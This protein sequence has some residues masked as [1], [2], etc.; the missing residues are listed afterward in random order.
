MLTVISASALNELVE[1]M[2]VNFP[3]GDF[4]TVRETLPFVR[5]SV[6]QDGYTVFSEMD[7]A[8]CNYYEALTAQ[9]LMENVDDKEQKLAF[10]SRVL[11]DDHY[12]T[13]TI[14]TIYEK[15]DQ[16]AWSTS[17]AALQAIE[18]ELGQK[19]WQYAAMVYR[20]AEILAEHGKIN[21]SL[22][23]VKKCQKS[24]TSTSMK[25]HWLNGC[26][27]II[28][29]V[30]YSNLQKWDDMLPG[31]QAASDIFVKINK[32]IME[33]K[34]NPLAIG[35]NAH[36]GYYIT[37]TSRV[38]GL[39]KES[40]KSSESMMKHLES[41]EMDNTGLANAYRSNMAISYYKEK[42]Y[43]KS[44]KMM[45]QYLDYLEKKGEKGSQMYNYIDN[46]LKQTPR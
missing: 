27:H 39:N 37:T 6:V 26:L 9:F 21:E 12:M 24:Y 18:D 16:S 15:F 33:N 4:Y 2:S 3:D 8:F 41:M 31:Y 40:I 11:G 19:S 32:D 29:S 5:N 45:T 44:R 46:L 25:N 7:E 28:Q 35:G 43:K 36:L 42:N 38:F 23:L 30:L 17:Q 1:K 34:M 10:N 13:L 20:Q 14:K 22:D